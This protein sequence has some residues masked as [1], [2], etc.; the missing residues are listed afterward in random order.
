VTERAR[1]RQELARATLSEV[2]SLSNIAPDALARAVANI[3]SH[4]R[5]VL[6]FHPDR[7]DERERSVAENLLDS[8]LYKSQFETLLSN[9]SLSAFPNGQRDSW[10]RELFGGA[11]QRDGVRAAHRPNTERST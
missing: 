8:G 6:H 9:G 10:E 7:L 3:R 1:A 5:V 2:C 4:A 11:Y